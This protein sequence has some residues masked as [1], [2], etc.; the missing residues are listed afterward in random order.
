MQKVGLVLGAKSSKRWISMRTTKKR[1]NILPFLIIEVFGT[2][3]LYNKID[4]VQHAFFE[5]LVLYIAKRLPFVV[6]C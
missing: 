6:L 5:N 3:Q 4:P 2:Q 1:K